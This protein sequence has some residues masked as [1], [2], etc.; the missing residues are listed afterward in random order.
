M[1]PEK[2]AAIKRNAIRSVGLERALRE[3]VMAIL[4]T[5]EVRQ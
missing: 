2:A 4:A 5:A 3:A 1:D